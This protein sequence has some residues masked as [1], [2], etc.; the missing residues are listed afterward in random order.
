[1][2]DRAL[3][4]FTGVAIQALSVAK[5]GLFSFEG[6]AA[7]PVLDRRAL[8]SYENVGA[9][10]VLADRAL[11]GYANVTALTDYDDPVEVHLLD[12]GLNV[13]HVLRVK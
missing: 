13:E 11:M 4:A 3:Y 12:T 2:G 1:M 10:P 5:R 9:N 6:V 7:N 8:V